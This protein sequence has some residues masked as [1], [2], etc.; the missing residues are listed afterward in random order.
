MAFSKMVTAIC[1]E[2]GFTADGSGWTQAEALQI[3][4]DYGWKLVNNGSG[5][6]NYLM[7]YTCLISG[8]R[9]TIDTL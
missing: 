1:D 3:V 9:P 2:C 7:C 6:Y 8:I 5:Q 4:K